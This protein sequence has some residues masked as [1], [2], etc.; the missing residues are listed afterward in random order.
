MSNKIELTSLD[1]ARLIQLAAQKFHMVMLNKT[2]INKILFIIYGVYLAKTGKHLFKDDKPKAWPFGPVF[3]RVYKNIDTSEIITGF[4]KDKIDEFKH[5]EGVLQLVID[6]VEKL[7]NCSAISLTRWSHKEGS[8]WYTTIYQ[9]DNDNNI[10]DQKK[11]NSEITDQSIQEYFQHPENC[12]N[13]TMKTT[14]NDQ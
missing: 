9:L 7:Y 14:S 10:I 13:I 5:E 1:Y 11:W 3:P 4:S 8:P 12:F 2:Q 6:T